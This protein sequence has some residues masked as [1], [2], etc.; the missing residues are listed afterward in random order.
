MP[1]L[2]L[3]PGLTIHYLSE[4]P[5]GSPTV[6]LLHGLG[7]DCTSWQLQIP[8]LSQ[9]GFHVLAP[10]ARGFGKSSYP[11]GRT[12]IRVMAEDFARLII[13]AARPPVHVVGIS[14]GGTHA[15]Q[16]CLDHPDLVSKLMVVNTFASLRPE[17][18]GVLAFLILRF[19]MV[20]TLGLPVQA[21]YVTR[22]IFP[23]EEQTFLREELYRQILQANPRAYRAAMR[24]LA[25]FRVNHRL[26]EITK[27]TLVVSGERDTTVPARNQRCL[28][29]GIPGAR[30]MIIPGAGHAA[31]VDQP[32]IFNKI[33][34]DFLSNP[35]SF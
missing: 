19:I 17:K 13:A 10:D 33:M 16:L 25:V 8:E 7:A 26:K 22:R 5:S 29:E 35:D 20:H 23:G 27:L 28:V 18:P 34:L 32:G 2:E 14:M 30:Q 21:R 1:F 31:T 24:A 12:T 3:D 4:N 6:V 15:L 11:G 9:G